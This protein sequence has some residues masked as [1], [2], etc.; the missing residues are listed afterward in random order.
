MAENLPDE[1]KLNIISRFKFMKI[2]S[3]RKVV[4]GCVQLVLA[5]ILADVVWAASAEDIGVL[6][7]HGAK[8]DGQHDDTAAFQGAI[9]ALPASGGTLVVPPGIY[10]I[11][12]TKSINLRSNMNIHLQAGAIIQAIP[13]GVENYAILK[14]INVDNVN[15]SGGEIIGDRDAHQGNKGEWGMGVDLR[16]CKRV[17]IENL[18][19]KKCWGDGIYLGHS[20][21]PGVSG[22][23]CEN[24]TLKNVTADENRRQGLSIVGCIGAMILGC[25]FIRTHGTAPECGI[26]LE[27]SPAK[28]V[29]KIIINNCE[30]HSNKGFGVALSGA[31]VVNNRVE[32]CS[33][34][35][36]GRDGLLLAKAMATNISENQFFNNGRSGILLMQSARGNAIQ[37]NKFSNTGTSKPGHYDH[38]TVRGGSLDNRIQ[39]N[40]FTADAAS[41]TQVRFDIS[42]DAGSKANLVGINQREGAA[43]P[44]RIH[45]N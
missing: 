12:A 26:D 19:V 29:E 34:H 39:N 9:N 38:I 32:K 40:V 4:F 10:M 5:N 31:L 18:T 45:G 35:D 1:I 20:N 7:S 28:R 42:L 30:L 14:A 33:I 44:L 16:G 2:F 17:V 21:V 6:K 41:R 15:I 25:R 13:C 11:D 22:G 8:G 3:K 36:N 23:E 43:V 24:I 37:N 27:P